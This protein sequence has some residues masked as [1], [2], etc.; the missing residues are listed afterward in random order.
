MVSFAMVGCSNDA[1]FEEIL[2]RILPPTAQIALTETCSMF[3]GA[4]IALFS[5]VSLL[6]EK[7][8]L[9]H[10]VDGLWVRSSSL[11]EFA[12]ADAQE[13]PGSGVGATILDG[14]ECLRDKTDEAE[15]ILFGAK[16]GLYFRSENREIVAIIFD[17]PKGHGVVFLQAP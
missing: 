17:E 13:Y 14:K 4:S 10:A 1:K 9:D 8:L 7:S 5:G 15:E 2:A 6:S 11:L 3:L 12:E 16:A